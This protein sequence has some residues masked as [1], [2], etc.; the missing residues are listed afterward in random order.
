MTQ[1][2]LTIILSVWASVLSTLLAIIKIYEKWQDRFRIETSYSFSPPEH[3]GNEIIIEN[4]TDTPVMIN[5][6]QLLWI[7]G[8]FKKEITDGRS[9]DEGYC[10]ITIAAHGR[11]TLYFNELDYFSTNHKTISKGKLYLDLHVIGR[12]RPVRLQVYNPKK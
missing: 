6:W 10:S 5:Y 2:A 3:G 11:H 4:P 12:R 8:F 1:Q 9:P 7:K